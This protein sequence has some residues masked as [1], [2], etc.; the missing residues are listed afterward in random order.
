ME[1]RTAAH[2]LVLRLSLLFREKLATARLWREVLRTESRGT[3]VLFAPFI[4]LQ[5]PALNPVPMLNS[6]NDPESKK[7]WPVAL[8]HSQK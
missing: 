3:M 5:S 2:P 7:G 1:K 6:Y 8:V 4:L